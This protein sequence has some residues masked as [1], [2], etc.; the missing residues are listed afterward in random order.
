MA[1]FYDANVLLCCAECNTSIGKFPR[2]WK[3]FSNS[4]FFVPTRAPTDL[5]LVETG[6]DMTLTRDDGLKL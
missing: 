6:C 1:G 5:A 4:A 2:T 3:H